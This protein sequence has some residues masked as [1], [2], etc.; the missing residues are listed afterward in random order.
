MCLILFAYQYHPQYRLVLAA[1]RDEFFVRDTAALAFW[2][3]APHILAGRDLEK[4]GTWLGVTRNG[5]FAALTNYREANS[6]QKDGPSRGH[7]VSEYLKRDDSPLLYLNELQLTADRYS[8]FNLLLGDKE[9]MYYFSNRENSIRLLQSGVFGLSNRLLDSPWPK[10]ERG[11]EML[12]TY[13]DNDEIDPIR[14]LDIL[15]DRHRPS[16]EELPNTG[17]SLDWE[18]VLSPIFI[19]SDDY[20]TRSSTVL[21]IESDSGISMTE[22]GYLDGQARTSCSQIRINSTQG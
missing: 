22:R 7:L 12:L 11:K 15:N 21:L 10:L 19:T 6:P 3:D 9:T 13:L 14:L 17:V 16:D 8:G 4:G 2:Q 20:G 5:R 1:N 18:R